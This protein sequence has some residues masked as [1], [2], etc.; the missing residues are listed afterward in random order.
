MMILRRLLSLVMAAGLVSFSMPTIAHAADWKAA[1]CAPY[2]S[3]GHS[4]GLERKPARPGTSLRVSVTQS[5]RPG[6]VERIPG[7][8]LTHW[9]V[10]D[11]RSGRFIANNLTLLVRRGAVPGRVVTLSVRVRGLTTPV[12]TSFRVAEANEVSL[13]GFYSQIEV[14][15]CQTEAGAVPVNIGELS[16]DDAGRFSVTWQPFES[17]KDYWGHYAYDPA[18][19]RIVLKVEGGNSLPGNGRWEGRV[20][21]TADGGLIFDQVAFGS[22]D[23]APFIGSCRTEFRRHG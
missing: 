3:G 13:V 8:C 5:A 12:E 7:V 2:A 11:P 17:Y 15:G 9:K 10:S 22:A 4:L 19:G 20:A 23:G 18:T 14:R 6:V 16:F 21:L 1:K